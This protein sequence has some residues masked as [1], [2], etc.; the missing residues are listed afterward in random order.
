MKIEKNKKKEEKKRRKRET[1]QA[2]QSG[3]QQRPIKS[4]PETVPAP[5]LSSRHEWSPPASLTD[6]TLPS[7]SSSTFNRSYP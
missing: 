7:E 1:D 4:I 2:A 5:S 6:G 3:Q